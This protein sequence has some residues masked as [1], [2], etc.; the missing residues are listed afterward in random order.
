M[1]ICARRFPVYCPPEVY[2]LEV[3]GST[4]FGSESSCPVVLKG[5]KQSERSGLRSTRAKVLPLKRCKRW[6]SV[7]VVGDERY[8][9]GVSDLSCARKPRDGVA[10]RPLGV[11]P[12]S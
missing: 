12:P 6:K 4:P 1:F 8:W 11:E 10:S 2:S 5:F 9:R 3:G 7:V